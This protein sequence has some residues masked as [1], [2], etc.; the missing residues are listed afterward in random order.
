MPKSALLLLSY[1][2]DS[3]KEKLIDRDIDLRLKISAFTFLKTRIKNR[4]LDL[5]TRDVSECDHERLGFFPELFVTL[6]PT[7]YYKPLLCPPPLAPFTV[8]FIWLFF[9]I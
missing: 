5:Y 1:L 6:K 8:I 3:K 4:I 9:D 7:E 2:E